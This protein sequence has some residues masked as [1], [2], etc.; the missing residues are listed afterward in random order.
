MLDQEFWQLVARIQGRGCEEQTTEVKAAARGCP[1]RL[2]DTFSSFSN[3]D[4]GGVIV[5]GLDEREQFTKVGPEGRMRRLKR[6]EPIQKE[7]S[8][9]SAMDLRLEKER[10]FC[11]SMSWTAA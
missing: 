4:D 7:P 11:R 10:A 5:F 9:D 3:Q 2:Y 1:E 8:T 6:P